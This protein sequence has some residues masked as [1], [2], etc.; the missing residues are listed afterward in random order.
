M[1]EL[2]STITGTARGIGELSKPLRW[3]E[4]FSIGH[5]DLDEEHR[6]MIDLI[7]L[8][9]LACSTNQHARRS[10]ALLRE[11][12]TLTETHFEHEETMLEGLCTT[13]QMDQRIADGILAAKVEHTIEH[14]RRLDEL[15]DIRRRFHSTESAASVDPSEELKA[16]FID[17]AVG[18]EAQMKTLI[19]SV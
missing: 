14:R 3:S 19:Q 17:H 12:E 6:R 1:S 18:Y 9:C 16:W 13:P 4:A 7:N 8:I 2:L 11:L 15:R 10:L 5:P